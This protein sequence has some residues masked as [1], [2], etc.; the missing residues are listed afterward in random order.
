MWGF[1][2][3]RVWVLTYLSLPRWLTRSRLSF[4]LCFEP[5]HL[6]NNYWRQ[7]IGCPQVIPRR[8]A[9]VVS[10]RTPHF[11]FP[12][13]PTQHSPNRRCI[14]DGC[15]HTAVAHSFLTHSIPSSISSRCRRR[16]ALYPLA[17]FPFPS[18]RQ[19]SCLSFTCSSAV[20]PHHHT[21]S[22][23]NWGQI[24]NR[25]PELGSPVLSNT[26]SA[27]PQSLPGRLFSHPSF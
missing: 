22:F 11:W 6:G 1:F 10:S 20:K 23:G 7:M 19:N 14:F 3:T 16:A 9:V 2:C 17:Y 24:G 13:L 21:K 4:V 26:A 27:E 8:L 25:Q 18:E 12:A 5:Q 15:G